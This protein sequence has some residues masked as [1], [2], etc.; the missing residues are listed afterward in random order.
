MIFCHKHKSDAWLHALKS[1][2]SAEMWTFRARKI[3][4]G[5]NAGNLPLTGTLLP[6]VN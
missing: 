1:N 6:T 3:R 2:R 5:D 4:R